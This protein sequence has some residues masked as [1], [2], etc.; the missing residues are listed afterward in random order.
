MLT[1]CFWLQANGSPKAN[2][3]DSG[4]LNNAACQSTLCLLQSQESLEIKTGKS[5]RVCVCVCKR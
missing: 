1:N 4:Y 2:A 5:K 3:K